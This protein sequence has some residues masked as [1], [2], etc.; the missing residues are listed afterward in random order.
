MEH[1]TCITLHLTCKPRTAISFKKFLLIL[2]IEIDPVPIH[3]ALQNNQPHLITL[4]L[5]KF[6][7][8]LAVY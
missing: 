1:L 2:K 4:T 8:Y 7:P 3:Y 5:L 6:Y